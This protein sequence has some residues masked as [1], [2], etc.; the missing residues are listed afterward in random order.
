MI[1]IRSVTGAYRR[2]DINKTSTN[3]FYYYIITY[4]YSSTGLTYT[5][6]GFTQTS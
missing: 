6:A 5:D 1:D 3:G 2:V 4:S